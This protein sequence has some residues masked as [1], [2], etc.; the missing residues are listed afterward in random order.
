MNTTTIDRRE[1]LTKSLPTGAGL[2]LGCVITQALNS[3]AQ[4]AETKNAPSASASPHVRMTTEEVFALRYD[5]FVPV[6]QSLAKEMG[7]E[8]CLAFLTKAAAENGGQMIAAAVKDLP[9]RDI[10]ALTQFLKDYLSTPPW[11]TALAGQINQHGD[12]VVELRHTQCVPAKLLRAMGAADIGYAIECSGGDAA[13]KAF[14]P[15]MH[16]ENPKNLMKGDD[17]CIERFVLEA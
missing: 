15:K 11:D 14:N 3:A 4:A 10:A 12:K 2:C 9:K 6:M 17:V 16:C 13:A 8:K 5:T 7:R 1:F